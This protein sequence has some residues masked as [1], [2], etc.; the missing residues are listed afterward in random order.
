M[1]IAEL[2]IVGI[3]RFLKESVSLGSSGHR[4]ERKLLGYRQ[5]DSM[6]ITAELPPGRN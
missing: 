5:N 4:K 3:P 2:G 1:W 6:L